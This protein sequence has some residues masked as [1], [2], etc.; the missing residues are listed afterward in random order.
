MSS[1]RRTAV[2]FLALIVNPV[3]VMMMVG[4]LVF[5][6]Q[7]S[8]Y[9]G[10]FP[11]RL[12]W[13]SGLFVFA[14]VLIAWITIEMGRTRAGLYL[15]P[16][17]I[18]G[19]VALDRFVESHVWGIPALT[20]VF[21]VMVVVSVWLVCHHVMLDCLLLDEGAASSSG[22]GL[23]EEWSQNDAPEEPAETKNGSDEGFEATAPGAQANR[24]ISV[25]LDRV[26][27]DR[28][29]GPPGRTVLYVLLGGLLVIAVAGLNGPAQGTVIYAA[30]YVVAGLGLLMT[31]HLLQLR[32]YLRQRNLA[33]PDDAVRGWVTVGS[34]IVVGALL[35]AWL[36]PKPAVP[37][38]SWGVYLTSPLRKA[39]SLAARTMEPANTPAQRGKAAADSQPSSQKDVG[40]PSSGERRATEQTSDGG[41]AEKGN[42]GGGD[43]SATS[44]GTE[45]H[46]ENAQAG[47]EHGDKRPSEDAATAEDVKR[48]EPSQTPSAR[49]PAADSGKSQSGGR[50]PSGASADAAKK[51]DAGASQHGDGKSPT[52]SGDAKGD[53]AGGSGEESARSQ[54]DS[55]SENHRSR[56][57]KPPL[58]VDMTRIASGLAWL[59]RVLVTLG[60][61]LIVAWLAW[62]YRHEVWEVLR[63]WW[64]QLGRLLESLFG[65]RRDA[66]K[67][68]PQVPASPKV[69]AFASFQ[70]PF[71]SGA[72]VRQ[73][74]IWLVV[75]SFDALQAW[76]EGLGV[77]RDPDETPK[78]YARRLRASDLAGPAEFNRLCELYNLVAYAGRSG[79]LTLSAEDRHALAAAWRHMKSCGPQPA[80]TGGQAT[81]D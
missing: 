41:K 58:R 12:R 26:Y 51:G 35:L 11:M 37:T 34:V 5:L 13:V 14:A 39:S 24:A 47:A 8:F 7:E 33:M 32:L 56:L 77:P 55:G 31:T 29:Q 28:P 76:G 57:A 30:S 44:G 78:E 52:R 10:D 65:R 21:H 62:R 50:T 23:L 36:L 15:S 73:S 64:E 61:L 38:W 53:R 69:P 80:A 45:E 74:P 46:Q 4:S 3:L 25:F 43:T 75:Y 79:T 67:E 18:L 22:K 66:G 71:A 1:E 49:P 68:E 6:L 19:A 27:P 60:F 17:L 63:H 9:R 2:D 81:A 20:T 72:A 40:E 48:N 70:D 42:N 59:F 54:A 16:L